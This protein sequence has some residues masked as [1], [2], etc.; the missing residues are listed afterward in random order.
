MPAGRACICVMMSP[1]KQRGTRA[2]NGKESCPVRSIDSIK[3]SCRHASH[4]VTVYRS[5]LPRQMH[6]E[7]AETSSASA[8]SSWYC[9]IYDADCHGAAKREVTLDDG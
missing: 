4:N 7:S 6:V 8:N 5:S 9:E 2:A 3:G 1:F